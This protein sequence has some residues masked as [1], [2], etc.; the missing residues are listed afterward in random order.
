[1]RWLINLGLFF[2]PFIAFFAYARWANARRLATGREPL[3]PP[4]YWLVMLGLVFAVT[5]FFILR[6]FENPH[7]GN[8]IPASV[9]PDGKLIPGHYEN[10]GGPP[11]VPPPQQ[12][13][14]ER[15][16]AEP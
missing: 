2:L 14:L 13:P 15:P 7:T 9:G 4:W 8:Y 11:Y 1:M 5:G 3:L 10:D 12:P 6:A 16:P